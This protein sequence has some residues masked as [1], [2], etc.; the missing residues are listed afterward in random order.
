MDKKVLESSLEGLINAG[1]IREESKEVVA[2]ALN[3]ASETELLGISTQ[4]GCTFG[5]LTLFDDSTS[6]GTDNKPVRMFEAH[7]RGV[8]ELR[9]TQDYLRD[10]TRDRYPS[11]DINYS[12]VAIN[13]G[14]I[15][16]WC[17]LSE[18]GHPESTEIAFGGK[19]P[20]LGATKKVLAE[21]LLSGLRYHLEGKDLQIFIA[22]VSDGEF[23]DGNEHSPEEIATL[24]H[25]LTY[26]SL[27]RIRGVAIGPE[28][29]ETFLNMG[30][31]KEHIIDGATKNFDFRSAFFKFDFVD[32]VERNFKVDPLHER[33]R[34]I[35]VR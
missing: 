23:T 33:S 32:R 28:A 29:K 5:A 14:T 3:L 26:V 1:F 25:D 8:C 12:S 15:Q 21:V 2:S 6:M 27:L 24:I 18:A 7:R 19:S 4:K 31:S 9:R 11:L 22:I 17:V 34:C 10:F 30:I 35:G 16:P 13:A 20:L